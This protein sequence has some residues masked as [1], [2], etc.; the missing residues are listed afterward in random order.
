MFGFDLH[1]YRHDAAENLRPFEHVP[2]E[3]KYAIANQ[4]YFDS[5][6]KIRI[7]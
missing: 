4:S 5:P 1:I 6:R 7:F 2:I 3:D